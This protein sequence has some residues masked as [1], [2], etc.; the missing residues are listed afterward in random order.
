[1]FRLVGSR[2]NADVEVRND[3][4]VVAGLTRR[5]STRQGFSPAQFIVDA[6]I[7][8]LGKLGELKR[9]VRSQLDQLV[10]NAESYIALWQDYQAIERDNL[11]K[12]ARDAGWVKYGSYRT[13]ADGSWDFAV[14]DP[15]V[16]SAFAHGV[17]ESE[18]DLEISETL[19][20]GLLRDAP[21]AVHSPESIESQ[22]DDLDSVGRSALGRLVSH[23]AEKAKIRLRPV[24][25]DRDAVPPAQG[26]IHIGILGDTVSPQRRAR[27]L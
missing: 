4:Y 19:P 10:R 6:E 9:T 5:Q 16:L 12:D 18:A 26:V 22:E 2:F 20:P 13:L 11:I 27:A 8:V 23:D 15:S 1:R 14:R 25:E 24:D 3:S 21:T 7:S 17:E